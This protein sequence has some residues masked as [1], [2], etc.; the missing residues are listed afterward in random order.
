M[1]PRSDLTFASSLTN[2]QRRVFYEQHKPL[3]V[4]MILILFF[5]PFVGLYTGGLLGTVAGVIISVL[6]YYLA[7]YT[8]HRLL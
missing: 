2:A 4:G 8:V 7:P 5:F 1:A 6:A 3:A